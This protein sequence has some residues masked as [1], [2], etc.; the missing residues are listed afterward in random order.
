M[1]DI[2][3]VATEMSKLKLR[4]DQTQLSYRDASLKSRREIAILKRL[5]SR[6]SVACRGLDQELDEKLLQLRHDLEQNKD[7]GKM[8]PRLAVVERLVTRLSDFADKENHALLEQIHHSSEMLRRFHGLP[9]QLKRDL[10]NLL[11]QKDH[12]LAHTHQQAIRLMA[13]YERALKVVSCAHSEHPTASIH[14]D[15]QLKLTGELQNLITELDFEGEAGDKLL[16]IRNQLLN[17]VPPSTLM[18]LSLEI[19]R[20]VLDGTHQERR[21]SQRFL[22][23][24][25]GELATLQKTTHQSADQSQIIFEHRATMTS[26]LAGLTQT[27][28]TGLADNTNLNAWRPTLTDL[29][30]ELQILAER[31]KALEKRE[32]AL[33]E[34]LSYNE[35]KITQ[36]CEQTQ[37]YRQRLSDQEKRIFLDN[38]TKVYN[39]AA[40]NDRLEHEYRRWLRYQ[41]PLCVALIDIDNFKAINENYGH[42]AGDKVLKIIARTLSQS[43]ADT[44][45]IARF[46]DDA[47]MVILAEQNEDERQQCLNKL[48]QAVTQLPFRFR[49]RNVTISVSIGATL[50]DGNDTPT[51]VLE[52]TEKALFSAR[53]TGN[54]RLLW[55]A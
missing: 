1:T 21:T 3:A 32:Q 33:L 49:D 24:I 9:A 16:Q 29:T 45:F 46:S 20:L 15:L 22:N 40:L 50:F 5:I 2:T 48:R 10:R 19:L 17:G 26:E 55:I 36:L 12:S 54:N 23:N 34:Q 43:V 14:H 28:K 35:S 7:I 39:R 41:H 31:N 51:A 37:D 42:F 13:L 38:L 53:S 11:A 4:L 8:I 52:R 18:E 44:D 6:L 47:F 30:R 25:T 27:L